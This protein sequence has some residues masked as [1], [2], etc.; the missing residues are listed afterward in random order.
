ECEAT[1]L[2]F[3]DGAFDVAYLVAVLHHMPKE[4][5][6]RALGEGKRVAAA[7][8]ATVW[9]PDRGREVAPGVWEVPW[10]HKAVRLYYVYSLGDLA[11]MAGR[12][13][14]SLGV[15]RRGRQ[16]NL[17]LVIYKPHRKR[18]NKIEST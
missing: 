9:R 17:Y 18:Y 6:E 12:E 1:L 5:A 16:H 3:R 13:A 11:E 4:A 10:G 7:V 2:P 14:V 8:V 15:M